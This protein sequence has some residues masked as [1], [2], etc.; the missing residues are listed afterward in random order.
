MASIA[1]VRSCP[2]CERIQRAGSNLPFPLQ[3][4]S[5]ARAA[6][7]HAACAQLVDLGPIGTVIQRDDQHFHACMGMASSP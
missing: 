6:I 7:G 2:T 5:E 3:W 1:T 4:V